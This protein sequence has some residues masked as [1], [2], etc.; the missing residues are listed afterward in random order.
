M[1]GG[2]ASN[3]SHRTLTSRV[4]QLTTNASAATTDFAVGFKFQ[5]Q[6]IDDDGYDLG[7]FDGDIVEHVLG[8]GM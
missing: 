6:F 8:T 5:K 4:K 7:W 2:K 1:E 3:T